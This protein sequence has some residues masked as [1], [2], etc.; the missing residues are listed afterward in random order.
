MT[1][2]QMC[3]SMTMT[4][5]RTMT[6]VDVACGPRTARQPRPTSTTV[7]ALGW[8]ARVCAARWCIWTTALCGALWRT[9]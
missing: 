3:V 6:I 7:D 2:G 8:T 1:P 9:L 4:M 5:Y